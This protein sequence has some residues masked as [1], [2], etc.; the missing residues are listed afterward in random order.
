ME[1]TTGP[2]LPCYHFETSPFLGG[3]DVQYTPRWGLTVFWVL[4][5]NL[6][7]IPGHPN[8]HI[9]PSLGAEKFRTNERIAQR[10][11]FCTEEVAKLAQT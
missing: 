11:A 5:R 4:D 7:V 3:D 10:S 1:S 9:M 6:Q 8:L 2:R